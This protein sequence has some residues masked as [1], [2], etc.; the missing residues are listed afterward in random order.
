M[1]YAT[2]ALIWGSLSG[3]P[4]VDIGPYRKHGIGSMIFSPDRSSDICATGN[5][6][7]Y[8]NCIKTF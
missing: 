6:D 4:N 2:I 7:E 5:I 3:D 1:E 8:G